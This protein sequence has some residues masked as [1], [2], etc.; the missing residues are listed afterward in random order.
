LRL[1]GLA[2]LVPDIGE[3]GGRGLLAYPALFDSALI[4]LLRIGIL[5]LLAIAFLVTQPQLFDGRLSALLRLGGLLGN[6][7]RFVCR[8]GYLI[9][10]ARD[11]IHALDLAAH[12]YLAN[13]LLDFHRLGLFPRIEASDFGGIERSNDLHEA[14]EFVDVIDPV[15]PRER[16][17]RRK[18][19]I[20]EERAAEADRHGPVG[21]Q[22]VQRFQVEAGAGQYLRRIEMVGM[23]EAR[24][25]VVL[26]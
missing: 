25:V 22:R 4:R 8:I 14:V 17:Q 11:L 13:D 21:R 3:F 9:I 16:Y 26:S 19:D 6:S 7:S 15:A 2:Q 10:R 12:R 20:S 24:F 1:A 23:L 5:L 18:R